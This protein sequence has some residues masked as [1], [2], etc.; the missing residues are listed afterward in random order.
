MRRVACVCELSHN[1][2]HLHLWFFSI[3]NVCCEFSTCVAQSRKWCEP[4]AD[5]VCVMTEAKFPLDILKWYHK[6]VTIASV[7]N[8]NNTK[9]IRSKCVWSTNR[10]Q[11]QRYQILSKEKN[12]ATFEY[13]LINYSKMSAVAPAV[14]FVFFLSLSSSFHRNMLNDWPYLWMELIKHYFIM[15]WVRIAIFTSYE[16]HCTST[17]CICID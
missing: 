12:A 7:T 3:W 15:V 8:N 9:Y 6:D 16:M 14:L 11:Q 2:R 17:W 10:H 5:G 13:C 4:F 1:R